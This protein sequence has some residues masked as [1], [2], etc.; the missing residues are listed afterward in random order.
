MYIN[1]YCSVYLNP[2]FVSRDIMKPKFII[3]VSESL[4]KQKTR[5]F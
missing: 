1:V 2:V 4:S 5:P 3:A